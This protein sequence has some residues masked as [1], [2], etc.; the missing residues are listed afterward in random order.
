MIDPIW[1]L[2]VQDTTWLVARSRPLACFSGDNPDNELASARWVD[3]TTFEAVTSA[4]V[5]HR[6]RVE[7]VDQTSPEFRSVGCDALS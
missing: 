5:T 6:F 7:S 4:G 3:D 2:A 1:D